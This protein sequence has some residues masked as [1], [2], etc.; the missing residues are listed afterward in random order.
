MI[1]TGKNCILLNSVQEWLLL[2]FSIYIHNQLSSIHSI[3][4]YRC[5]QK[6]IH[7]TDSKNKWFLLSGSFTAKFGLVFVTLENAFSYRFHLEV[8]RSIDSSK[9]LWKG[10]VS[11]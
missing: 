9:I 4:E 10:T 7:Q 1:L 2:T 11:A 3:K 5:L 6:L 8:K